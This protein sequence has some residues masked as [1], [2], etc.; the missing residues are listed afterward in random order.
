MILDKKITDA[1]LSASGVVSAPDKLTGT[2]AENKAVFDRLVREAVAANMNGLI[3]DLAASTGA[4]N[5]GA[6][7]SGAPGETIQDALSSLQDTKVDKVAGKALSTNDYTTAEKTKLEGIEENANNYSHPAS[8]SADMINETDTRKFVTPAE[9]SGWSAKLDENNVLTK[10]NTT[11]FTPTGDYQPATKKYADELALSAGAV[12]SVFGRSGAVIAQ[13]GD[14][15]PQMV[16]A[17]PDTWMPTPGEIGAATVAVYTATLT[18]AGWSQ[19]APYTQTVSIEGI[20]ETDSPIFGPAY[21]GTND[22]KIAQCEAWNMVNEAD[23]ASG[24]VTFTCF[25]D[26]PGVDINIQIKAVR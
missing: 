14:Y 20:G 10:T 26:K 22:E 4:D 3:D 13:A 7:L 2:A 25:E 21:T 1:Q 5:I 18:A 6:N 23:T 15:T 16:G 12:T 9:K 24:S 17:R 11:P 19:T 8:H